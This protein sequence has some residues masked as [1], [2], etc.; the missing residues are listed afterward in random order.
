M[1]HMTV[2]H[3]VRSVTVQEA[4]NVNGTE[5]LRAVSNWKCSEL[6]VRSLT[7]TATTIH[8][9]PTKITTPLWLT[10]THIFSDGRRLGRDLVHMGV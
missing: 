7:S 2:R 8:D 5:L 9:L 10:C 6:A 4:Q 1:R 3:W